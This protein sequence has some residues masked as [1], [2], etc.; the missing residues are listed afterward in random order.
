MVSIINYCIYQR[1]SIVILSIIDYCIDLS[2]AMPANLSL[3]LSLSPPPLPP[4]DSYRG[5]WWLRGPSERR[6]DVENARHCLP[7]HRVH[8]KVPMNAQVLM[9][10]QGFEGVSI[11]RDSRKCDKRCRGVGSVQEQLSKAILSSRPRICKRGTRKRC[12]REEAGH[13]GRE[14]LEIGLVHELLQLLRSS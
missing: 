6:D 11:I 2:G 14:A 10:E 7:L 13:Q 9:K 4:S 12:V 3:S 8:H 5:R 1:S